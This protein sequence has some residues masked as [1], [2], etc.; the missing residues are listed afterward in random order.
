MYSPIGEPQM[1]TTTAD[2]GLSS[3]GG[4]NNTHYP[5]TLLQTD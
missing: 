4:P 5:Q 1:E 2:S 3:P